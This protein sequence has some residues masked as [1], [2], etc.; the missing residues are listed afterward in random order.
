MGPMRP[1]CAPEGS[2]DSTCASFEK[3]APC[4][5]CSSSC[6]ALSPYLTTMR[7]KETWGLDAP[8]C[9]SCGAASRL[10]HTPQER[11]RKARS[12]RAR[13]PSI[14]AYHSL[15]STRRHGG[16]SRRFTVHSSQFVSEEFMFVTGRRFVSDPHRGSRSR[17]GATG[18]KR[19]GGLQAVVRHVSPGRP[20]RGAD[21]G[22]PAPDDTRSDLQRADA[23]PHDSA[24]DR[25]ERG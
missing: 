21:A 18:A 25:V 6:A 7:R 14:P 8:G 19:R 5:S 9:G 13:F 17:R 1:P 2:S 22:H 12:L 3:S 23:G 15:P 24:G 4:F 10:T 16:S 11:R 20:E